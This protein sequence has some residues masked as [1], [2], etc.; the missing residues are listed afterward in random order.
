MHDHTALVLLEPLNHTIS[1]SYFI[2]PVV[3]QNIN[4]PNKQIT[5]FFHRIGTATPI[6]FFF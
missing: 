3:T 5:F 4:I 2:L 1:K 6:P